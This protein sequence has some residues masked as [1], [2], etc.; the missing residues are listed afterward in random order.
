MVAIALQLNPFA[1]LATVAIAAAEGEEA[2][3]SVD[4]R[5]VSELFQAVGTLSKRL[6]VRAVR[7]AAAVYFDV[8][9]VFRAPRVSCNMYGS[10]LWA[11]QTYLSFLLFWAIT[12]A[13]RVAMRMARYFILNLKRNSM[14]AQQNLQAKTKILLWMREW[15]WMVIYSELLQ[16]I[17]GRQ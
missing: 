14:S 3:A 5:G 6:A 4:T 15:K 12:L 8:S 2:A 16:L 7:E 11:F 9:L 13:A 1:P 17:W 10:L